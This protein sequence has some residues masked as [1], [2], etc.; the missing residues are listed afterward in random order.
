MKVLFE[1]LTEE[2]PAKELLS[3]R[4]DLLLSILDKYNIDYTDV[5]VYYTPR[6]IAC[7]FDCN[8]FTKQVKQKVVGPPKSAC[9]DDKN[10][11]T[12]ALL[13]FLDKNNAILDEIFFE[14][15]KKG[16]YVCIFKKQ[17]LLPAKELLCSIFSEFL[18]SISFSK[19]MRW[20]RGDYQFLRPVHNLVLLADNDVVEC[21]MFGK[22]SVSYT[23]GHR[24]LSEGKIELLSKDY[25]KTLQ[26]HFVIVDQNQRQLFIK[27]ALK[28]LSNKD[29]QYILDEDLL[30][31]VTN[32]V[33][34]PHCIE[35]TFEEEFLNLPQE[36]LISSMKANQKYF[37]SL[38]NGKLTNKF[39][40]V[41][42]IVTDDDSLIVKG[43]ER[44]LK[45]RFR[46]AAFF[47]QEDLKVKLE[48]LVEKLKNMLF[49]KKLGSMYD[50]TVRLVEL[51]DQMASYI[52][53]QK[54]VARRAAYLS[55]AD[56]LTHMVYEFPE[57]QGVVGSLLAKNQS[58]GES[59][60]K[61][62]YEQ[63][64]PKGEVYPESLEGIALSLAD[65]IDLIIGGMIAD[66]RP[67]GNK[68]PYGLRRAALSI[69]KIVLKSKLSLNIKDAAKFALSLYEKQG[70]HKD[71]LDETL[72]F[73]KV[74]FMNMFEEHTEIVKSVVEV[75]FSDI[76]EAFLKIEAL[77]AFYTQTDEQ[78]LF[79]IKR[80]FNIVPDGF[81][82]TDVDENL[83]V[84]DEEANFYNYVKSLKHNLG[85]YLQSKDYLSYLNNIVDKK[86][87]SSF[88][89]KVLIMDKDEKIKNN[90]LALL[91]NYRQLVLKVADFKYLS[92]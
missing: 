53:A 56:L 20:G 19:Q 13:S 33:E 2:L 38:K 67:T 17:A 78:D 42:N 15:T 74:R 39:C 3:V 1:I 41:S 62:I 21:S 32:L 7:E 31:E 88:F 51:T 54:E 50:R 64:L 44:V 92:I 69:I 77:K 8:E 6:R 59:V 4:S 84:F 66:L 71:V 83:F 22:K 91:N 80:I 16:P 43:N 52:G 60:S 5:N 49:H 81:D 34:Y 70:L 47:Y 14:D 12:K 68:D 30:N 90:R 79:S 40:V 26:E 23:F 85:V 75:D 45:A 37:Y 87:I 9:F 86:I 72:E 25:K 36:V 63:Y 28:N 89:D 48:S 82:K 55:K 11:P 58:E 27:E 46:D 24:F 57:V 65:K 29:K 61:C 18:S 35:G 10:E 73:I 76:Y